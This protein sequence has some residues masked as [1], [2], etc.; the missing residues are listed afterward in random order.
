M[1]LI[2]IFDHEFGLFEMI[3]K[4][5]NDSDL[6]NL[7]LCKKW[8][9]KKKAKMLYRLISNIRRDFKSNKINIILP[10]LPGKS[11][12]NLTVSSIIK[13]YTGNVIVR[14]TK[15]WSLGKVKRQQNEN[16]PPMYQPTGTFIRIDEPQYSILVSYINIYSK[17]L[18]D[19]NT[20]CII[21]VVTFEP[22]GHHLSN[23]P[24][25]DTKKYILIPP[26]IHKVICKRMSRIPIEV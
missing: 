9:K 26:N 13:N 22:P 20:D 6:N 16:W 25:W 23:K 11:D 4:E 17:S 12:T 1:N 19:I 7:L 2:D 3:I 8:D 24:Y 14:R 21:G 15:G 10:C 5:L 18:G